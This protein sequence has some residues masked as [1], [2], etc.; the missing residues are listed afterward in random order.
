MSEEDTPAERPVFLDRLEAGDIDRLCELT[1]STGFFSEAEVL[2]VDELARAAVERG[3]ASGYHMLLV[4]ADAAR[5]DRPLGFACYGP[6]PCTEGSWHLYWVV[7]D[8]ARQGRGLGRA[9]Q[10]EV[11]RRV[12]ERGGRKL[13]LE[14]SDRPQ[15]APT[16]GFY[17][18]CGFAVEAR[19]ADYYQPGEAC[20]HYSREL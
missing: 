16:R 15:Y 2:I 5:R 13:F 8:P 18:S 4:V 6:V 12:R 7:V 11:E 10:A 14:T 19:L 20:L 1:R 17:E 3:E 9:I